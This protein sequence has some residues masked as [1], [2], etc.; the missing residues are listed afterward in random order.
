MIVR[1]WPG[2]CWCRP[3]AEDGRLGR[4]SIGICSYAQLLEYSLHRKEREERE[5]EI[6]RERGR[7][8]ETDRERERERE[9][10]R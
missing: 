4:H 6:E 7:K 2:S 8:R 9:G 1:E 5:R 10:E 3:Q